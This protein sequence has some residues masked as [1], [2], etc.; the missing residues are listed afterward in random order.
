MLKAFSVV[1]VCVSAAASPTLI[2]PKPVFERSFLQTEPE[3]P[4]AM[5]V[6]CL[7]P[8]HERKQ[9]HSSSRGQVLLYSLPRYMDAALSM[10]AVRLKA[11]GRSFVS[12]H[13]LLAGNKRWEIY[14][15]GFHSGILGFFFLQR[16]SSCFFFPWEFFVV[17][18]FRNVI[19]L[20]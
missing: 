10:S 15:D 1:S 13:E 16:A 3:P 14:N 19:L 17:A 11:T 7:N 6:A 2:L 9:T 4:A 20:L 5:T 12:L 8:R 18:F